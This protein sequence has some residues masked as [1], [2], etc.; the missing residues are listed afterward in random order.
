MDLKIGLVEGEGVHT[1]FGIT[2]DRWKVI[3][4]AIKKAFDNEGVKDTAEMGAALSEI[5]ETPGELLAAGM[6]IAQNI[7]D[8]NQKNKERARRAIHEAMS[9]MGDMFG[10]RGMFGR[11]RGGDFGSFLESLVGSRRPSIHVM[12]MGEGIPDEAIEAMEQLIKEHKEK[13]AAKA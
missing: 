3:T 10:G 5:C 8:R 9:D 4:D 12:D 1:R 13:S 2:D 7:A 11:G 6:S